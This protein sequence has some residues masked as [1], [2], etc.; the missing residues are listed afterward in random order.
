[1]EKNFDLETFVLE[2]VIENSE[3]ISSKKEFSIKNFQLSRFLHFGEKMTK[4]QGK[5]LMEKIYKIEVFV[6]NY[7][8]KDSKSISTKRFVW[9]TIFE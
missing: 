8:S 4:F 3:S 6:L 1:M 7:V 5:I 9:P 2:Y